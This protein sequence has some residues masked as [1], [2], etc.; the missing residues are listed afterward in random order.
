MLTDAF[1]T[2]HMNKRCSIPV[3]RQL[4]LH[5][6][7]KPPLARVHTVSTQAWVTVSHRRSTSCRAGGQKA[8]CASY[9][10]IYK[11]PH[12]P[13]FCFKNRGPPKKP[14]K[15]TSSLASSALRQ[16]QEE[17]TPLIKAGGSSALPGTGRRRPKE[18]QHEV[19]GVQ[20]ASIS[21]QMSYPVFASQDVLL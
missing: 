18:N 14:W 10:L 3:A 13:F 9:S 12:F 6:I 8:S 15:T 1:P 17:R 4:S 21:P 7:Q 2:G 5:G 11:P 19:L 20:P 16:T